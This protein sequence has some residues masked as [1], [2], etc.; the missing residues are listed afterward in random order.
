MIDGLTVLN[1]SI[2]I[3]GMVLCFL[4]VLTTAVFGK[5]IER[6]SRIFFIIFFTVL[7][8]D[9]IMN[10]FTESLTGMTD[11]R[12]RG[13]HYLFFLAHYL[14]CP[15]L[16]DIICLYLIGFV[17]D[18][19]KRQRYNLILLVMLLLY[20]VLLA[21]SN[22]HQ[23][24][25]YVDESGIVCRGD[26][27]VFSFA[28]SFL[29]IILSVIILVRERD[30]LTVGLRTALWIYILIPALA[31]IVQ[32]FVTRVHLI[33]PATMVSA[34]SLFIFI[35]AEQT[36]AYYQ[37][38][39]LQSETSTAIMLSQ[40]QPH[41]L[42]NALDS[43]YYLCEK[44]PKLA[45][46]AIADFS[47]YLRVNLRSVR[48]TEPIPFEIEKQH[49]ETYL[50][51]EKMSMEDKLDYAFDC[52]TTDFMI[53]VLA[54]Q[55]LVENAVKH[56]ISESVGGG[57][58]TVTTRRENGQVIVAVTDNGAGFDTERPDDG[59]THIGIENVRERLRMQCGGTLEIKSKVGEG[60]TAI[61]R[62]GEMS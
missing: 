20:I 2:Y 33:V 17:K 31:V 6:R 46:Q 58:V 60:T 30:S 12:S 4:G 16:A 19:Q 52:E 45:Q 8:L 35:I 55:P 11:E 40:I 43:I 61:I 38:L 47:K 29:P 41:F 44:D 15:M 59:H 27:Y 62:L 42:Y 48:Q 36:A 39:Q 34:L 24:Y 25:F 9:L 18:D 26:L 28:V 50:K 53:P 57:K 51:L 13:L 3:S 49:T 22:I 32:I 56:G 23:R 7:A 37:Q 5:T 14:F 10:I 54:L 21:L 1:Y